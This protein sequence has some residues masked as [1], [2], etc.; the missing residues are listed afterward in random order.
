MNPSIGGSEFSASI[1]SGASLKKR[2]SKKSAKS[3]EAA[4]E[5]TSKLLKIYNDLKTQEESREI[6]NK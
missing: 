2:D 4:S 1:P 5:K 3:L 6:T